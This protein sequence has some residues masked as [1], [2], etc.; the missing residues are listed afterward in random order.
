[1][2]IIRYADDTVFG[3]EYKQEAKRFL[4]DMQGRL[5]AFRLTLHPDKTQLIRFLRCP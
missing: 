3:F 5:Q 2:M 4:Q 1:M